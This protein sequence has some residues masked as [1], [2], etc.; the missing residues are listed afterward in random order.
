MTTTLI[1]KSALSKSDNYSQIKEETC[2][3]N[4]GHGNNEV[5]DE[6][7]IYLSDGTYFKYVYGIYDPSNPGKSV[8]NKLKV[9]SAD[10]IE[11]GFSSLTQSQQTE[12]KSLIED[13]ELK[14]GK[15]SESGNCEMPSDETLVFDA[16][17]PIED[18]EVTEN[19]EIS[20]YIF[21]D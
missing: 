20:L 12:L 19:P 5:T 4:N 21:T 1:T 3:S 18:P 10:G 14:G 11:I 17:E 16:P 9:Y 8:F 7:D 2:K 15:S 6:V 13:T